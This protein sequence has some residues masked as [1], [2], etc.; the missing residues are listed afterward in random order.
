MISIAIILA[1]GSGLRMNSD[2]PKQF[3]TIAGKSVL[4]YSIEAFQNSGLFRHLVIVCHPDYFKWIPDIPEISCKHHIISGG[5]S[6]NEST[7]KAIHYIQKIIKAGDAKLLFHDAARP[8]LSIKTIKKLH[9]A[10]SE[11]AV[12]VS[13]SK[14]NDTI[15]ETDLH[16]N[17]TG[18]KSRDNLVKAHTPQAFWFSII[19][20][21]YRI[22]SSQTE[23]DFTDDVSIVKAFIPDTEIAFI[24]DNPWNIKL[25]QP[26]DFSVLEAL[27]TD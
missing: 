27:L 21:A 26:D 5:A 20:D 25:T 7:E 6:R 4:Q 11:N 17:F 16:G 14:L 19:S 24:E 15:Y 22:K 18:I 1:G 23:E 10:L 9:N 3:L 12:A 2:L 8:N 13:V